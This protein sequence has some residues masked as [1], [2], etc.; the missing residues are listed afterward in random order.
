MANSAV[1]QDYSDLLA[2]GFLVDP[3]ISANISRYRPFF[4][5]GG[6]RK[7]GAYPYQTGMSILH[8]IALAGGHS[9]LAIT[10]TPPRVKR[11]SGAL[12]TVPVHT[13]VFP[14]DVIEIPER[15]SRK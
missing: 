9:E 8:A 3:K 11:A 4:I 1:G 6:V 12:E 13:P 14:G 2:N 15:T 7:P 5:I 10:D